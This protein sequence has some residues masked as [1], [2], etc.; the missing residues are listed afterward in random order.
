MPWST[1]DSGFYNSYNK[2][3]GTSFDVNK[4]KQVIIIQERTIP[5][6]I[7]A[8]YLMKINMIP[9]IYFESIRRSEAQY[10]AM[11]THINVNVEKPDY[12]VFTIEFNYCVPD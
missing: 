3:A 4:I 2:I 8:A 11:R 5:A 10:G 6:M 9:A 1:D 7:I 12:A